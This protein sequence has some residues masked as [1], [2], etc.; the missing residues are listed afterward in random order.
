ME[1]W[2]TVQGYT[3]HHKHV[4]SLEDR[5][6]LSSDMGLP[7]G[8]IIARGTLRSDTGWHARRQAPLECRRLH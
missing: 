2:T 1:Y 8:L 3:L 4:S 5:V 6:S 7:C